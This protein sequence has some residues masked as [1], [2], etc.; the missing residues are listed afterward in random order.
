MKTARLFSQFCEYSRQF[1]PSV[2][3]K[4]LLLLL[5]SFFALNSCTIIN[6]EAVWL[7]EIKTYKVFQVL[8]DGNALAFKCDSEYDKHCFGEVVFLVQREVPFYDGLKVTIAKP[9][10]EGTYRYETRDAFVKTV[11]IVR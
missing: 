4:K 3:M 1:K 10:M 9:I 2:K 5:V 6:G 7:Y 11:P 8:P